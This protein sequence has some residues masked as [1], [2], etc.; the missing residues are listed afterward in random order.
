M[1][2]QE[3]DAYTSALCRLGE[4]KEEKER[5][6][7]RGG[8]GMVRGSGAKDT[9]DVPGIWKQEEAVSEVEGR[10]EG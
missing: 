10:K 7:K 4:E 9:G 6:G 8:H 3:P 5:K 1:R 2:G